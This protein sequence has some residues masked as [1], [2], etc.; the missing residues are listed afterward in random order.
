VVRR[1][2]GDFAS[3]RIADLPPRLNRRVLGRQSGSNEI[4][5]SEPDVML[6]LCTVESAWCFRDHIVWNSI[7]PLSLTFLSATLCGTR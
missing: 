3:E 5:G 1:R 2:Y 7:E 4:G 6:E